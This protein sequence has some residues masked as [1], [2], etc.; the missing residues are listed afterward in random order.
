MGIEDFAGRPGELPV[1]RWVNGPE[2]GLDSP[3]ACFP[4]IRES[5]SL[6]HVSELE[7]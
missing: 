3:G 1:R 4:E 5:H 7:S 6:G 2:P